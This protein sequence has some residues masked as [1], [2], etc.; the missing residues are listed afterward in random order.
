MGR[1]TPADLSREIDLPLQRFFA[2]YREWLDFVTCFAV[3]AV[4]AF[5]AGYLIGAAH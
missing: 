2:E 1:K 4:I 3:V 5:C